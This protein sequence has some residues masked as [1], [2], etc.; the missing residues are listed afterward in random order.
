MRKLEFVERAKSQQL[1]HKN[2][3]AQNKQQ[4]R[5]MSY[6]SKNNILRIRKNPLLCSKCF[7]KNEKQGGLPPD[8]PLIPVQ[9][10]EETKNPLTFNRMEEETFIGK[11]G[12]TKILD[13]WSTSCSQ[14][15][16]LP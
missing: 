1:K 4:Y 16:L 6:S 8:L 11:K 15:G 5:G 13:L 3:N 10:G 14:S 9:S 2:E 7:A 12:E